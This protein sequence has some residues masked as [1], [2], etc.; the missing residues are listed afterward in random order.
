MLPETLA[1]GE[2]CEVHLT[3]HAPTDA[4]RHILEIDLVQERV[5]WFAERG[6]PTARV[7]VAI[8]GVPTAAKPLKMA[9][10][11]GEDGHRPSL[12]RRWLRPFR[13]GTPTFEMHVIPRAEV[14][15]VIERSGA[16]LLHAIDDGAAG[17]RWL[18]YTY[19]ARKA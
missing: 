9:E 19:V 2:A 3:V 12:L 5:C 8:A 13:R 11:P 16:T 10:G 7:P 6:S 14:E 1:P 4:G 15:A 18:S 17:Y